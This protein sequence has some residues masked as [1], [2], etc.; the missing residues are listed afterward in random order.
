MRLTP[1]KR[2]PNE[3][4]NYAVSLKKRKIKWKKK[5]LSPLLLHLFFFISLDKVFFLL[6]NILR[7]RYSSEILFFFCCCCC[8]NRLDAYL[9]ET[10]VVFRFFFFGY[11]ADLFIII[12]ILF[13]L[14]I[15]LAKRVNL[16][17]RKKNGSKITFKWKIVVKIKNEKRKSM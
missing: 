6:S 11:Y 9:T 4:K 1:V 16:S 13:F 10:N 12:S 7:Y 5:I 2:L 8:C 17:E 15:F 14:F 3:T